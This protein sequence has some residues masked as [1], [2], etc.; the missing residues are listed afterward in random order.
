[1]CPEPCGLLELPKTCSYSL[2]LT[3]ISWGQ[4][5]KKQKKE[6]FSALVCSERV[7]N[8]WTALAKSSL[9][10]V[11]LFWGSNLRVYCFLSIEMILGTSFPGWFIAE[12][13]CVL[14]TFLLYSISVPFPNS[15][16]MHQGAHLLVLMCPQILVFWHLG[17]CLATKTDL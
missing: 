4:K 2:S 17:K 12:K 6:S 5:G 15:S 3:S 11:S 13:A 8:C 9:T 10:N 14:V 7:Q 1:M 16:W